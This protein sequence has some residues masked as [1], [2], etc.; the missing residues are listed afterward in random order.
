MTNTPHSLA[1]IR[2]DVGGDGISALTSERAA[3]D[4]AIAQLRGDRDEARAEIERLRKAL[5]DA[6][7]WIDCESWHWNQPSGEWVEAIRP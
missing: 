5:K 2:G 1:V 7:Q 4:L 6:R 3:M